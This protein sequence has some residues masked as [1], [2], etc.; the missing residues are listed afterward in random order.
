MT[1]CGRGARVRE[2]GA[3]ARPHLGAVGDP[4][5]AERQ[6][7]LG[8]GGRRLRHRRGGRA[9]LHRG[10]LLPHLSELG[11]PRLFP[12]RRPRARARP[13]CSI[14][15]SPS[16]TSNGRRRGSCCSATTSP[17]RATAA[18][19]PQRARRPS[20]RHRRAAARR[21][22]GAGRQ[23]AA[24]RARG[25]VAQARRSGEP[26]EAA[27]RARRRLRPRSGAAPRSRSTTIRTSWGP[28]RSAR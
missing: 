24:Q 1:R 28:T 23:R 25:A 26:G 7:A 17:Q 4:G 11:Q 22:E 6:S 12:A 19:N 20:H 5:R 8:A 2:G 14:P 27:R 9:V 15:S 21:E 13:R 3:A 10:V 18:R 16:S